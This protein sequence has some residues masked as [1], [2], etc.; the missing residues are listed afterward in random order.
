MTDLAMIRISLLILLIAAMAASAAPGDPRPVRYH[1][2]G[3]D[4]VIHDGPDFFNRP[5]YGGNA[6]FRI[7][8]G[9]RPEFAIYLQG[10][11]G[12]LRLGLLPADSSLKALWLFDARSV[13]ARYRP[14]SMV[15]EIRDPL[16]GNGSLT[17]TAIPMSGTEGLIVRT[18][19]IG[20]VPPVRLVWAFGG[21]S[22]E[23]GRRNGDLNAENEPLGRF[24]QVMPSDCKD[25]H[26]KLRPDGFTL[27][28]TACTMVGLLPR[29]AKSK[30]ADATKWNNPALL[31]ESA[32][33]ATA[34]PVAAG[35]IPLVSA[36]PVFLGFHT[37][38][39]K[40]LPAV[41]AA[42]LAEAFEAAEAYRESL[43][44]RLAVKT[45]DP[46]INAA[47][48]AIT[49]AAD[50]IWDKREEAY[51]HGAVAWRV[52]LLGWRA[53]YTGDA[54]GWHERTRRHLAGFAARQDTSP[55]PSSIPPADGKFN[56]ARNESALHGNGDFSVV[57]PRHY[58][59]NLV[60]VDTL[61]RHLLWTGDL[62]FAAEMWPVLE[63]HLARER[64]LFR[65]TYG[66]EK[67]PLYE[68][69][70]CI[71]ASD[72]LIY[73]GGGTTHATAYNYWHNL[74]AARI[75]RLIGRDPVPYQN[76]ADLIDRAM[77]SELWLADRGWFAEYKDWLG[78]QSVHPDAG[79]WSFY[80][81]LDSQAATPLE[82]WQA[83]RFVDTRIARIPLRGPGVPEGN[84]TVA[85][86]NWMPYQW[87]INNVAL[88]ESAHTAL[89]YWQAG[90]A[91]AALPLFK[92][93]LLDAMFMGA[94]P[95]NVGM[96]SQS[97]TFSGERYRDFADAVGIT[98]RAMVE[99]LFGITPDLLAGELRVRPGFP[100]AWDH[101]EISQ[102]GIGFIF[103]REG[104]METYDISSRLAQPV[105]LTLE[106]PALRDRVASVTINGK[107]AD[108]RV[109]TDSVGAPRIAVSAPPADRSVVVIEWTGGK[110]DVPE[111]PSVRAQGATFS[112]HFSNAKPLEVKDPQGVLGNEILRD[113]QL[114][115]ET[116]GRNGHR[117]AFV[118]LE[119]GALEWWQPLEFELRPAIEILS[120]PKQDETGLR[121]RLRN[122]GDTAL[123]GQAA[124]TLARRQH[125][126]A[127][128]VPAGG[129]SAEIVLASESLPPG[130]HP[131]RVDFGG[132]ATADG[133]IVN[134]RLRPTA[135][136]A[137]W[138][139]VDLT[140][141]FNDRLTRIFENEYL[142]PRS[143]FCSLALPKQGI[144]GW[145]HYGLTAE[146]DDSG[147]RAAA[148]KS[149]GVLHSE[150]GIPFK[151]SGVGEGNN[152]LFTSLWD[153]HPDEATVPLTG[154]AARACLIMAG[155]TNSMQCRFDNGEVVITYAD[156]GASRLVLHSPVNWW[157]IEQDYHIDSHAFA[158]PEP[159]PP[160]LDLMTGRLRIMSPVDCKS[161]G[162]RIPGGAATILDLP[163][164]PARE[165]ESL[166]L[167]ALGNEV[168]I[169]L[170]A[171]TLDRGNATRN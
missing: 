97:D 87:S 67:L 151:T 162:K 38:R 40:Q 148:E 69:Y 131:V 61:L 133:V 134:W 1:P 152:I 72:E 12:N 111:F 62:A 80:H 150:L 83:S 82:A 20:P 27:P 75:A 156:G 121:F 107:T 65:R 8:A 45:P 94:C 93:S 25:N 5:L 144:G 127:L 2:E 170:M 46:H 108:W 102:P 10:R 95:G 35:E 76:E 21:A 74:M 51:M 114:L 126:M 86:T 117:T 85:T 44:G 116:T 138:E 110:P 164:D 169:G 77:K 28:L 18:E 145:C 64:R 168:I 157:P 60:G 13:T 118:R 22:G 154:H 142:S 42:G 4:F 24:F 99:G 160:R 49:V 153:N 43:V 3:T 109:L 33:K 9:D 30:L 112:V 161:R 147:L 123:T 41:V 122:N 92:G 146:I 167:R 55:V 115:A 32:G 130:S 47:A 17:V 143:P 90:R 98:S 125:S 70:A 136:A 96:T 68:A 79:V 50:A 19:T 39:P 129:E 7:E 23:R 31:L 124:V 89:A 37:V 54:L 6:G 36:R 53:A 91:D 141:H 71:W 26:F 105:K 165:L 15:Y 101:A 34:T 119:Q 100:A 88:A 163:L 137:G 132:G 113:H 171:L 58:N 139:A 56:L 66:P 11:C 57:E 52:R 63:R 81:T 120:D 159:V 14:G 106:I 29:G 128:N 140:K 158:R 78:K 48:A 16:L 166:T 103:R 84:F 135:S 149:G 59:M 104:L 155:T 73:N